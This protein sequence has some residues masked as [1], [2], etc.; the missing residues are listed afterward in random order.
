MYWHVTAIST[1]LG[2]TSEFAT[3]TKGKEFISVYVQKQFL[4]YRP[5]MC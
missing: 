2:Q 4:K 3:P 1:M 5:T